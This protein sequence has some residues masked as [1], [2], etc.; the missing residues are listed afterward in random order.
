MSFFAVVPIIFVILNE[1]K[2][3]VGRSERFFA[4]K[5]PCVAQNEE[6]A[7]FVC[8]VMKDR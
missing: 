2:D 8:S 5:I 7:C 1:V 4:N 3:L 6:E